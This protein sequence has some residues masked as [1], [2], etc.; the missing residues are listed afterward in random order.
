ML[1]TQQNRIG[2]VQSAA[3]AADW[4]AANYD[5]IEALVRRGLRRIAAGRGASHYDPDHVSEAI[6]MFWSAARRERGLGFDDPAA[7]D[8][9][10]RLLDRA[11]A[12]AAQG[13]ALCRVRDYVDA[14][15]PDDAWRRS[16]LDAERSAEREARIVADRAR[17][18]LGLP[19]V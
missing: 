5:R 2:A 16:K 11:V 8:R 17:V 4:F 12:D 19:T 13:R 3:A 6:A 14:S 10:Y 18:L 15:H 9:T 7:A 1:T